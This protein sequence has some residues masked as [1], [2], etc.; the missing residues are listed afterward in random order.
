MVERTTPPRVVQ[1][2]AVLTASDAGVWL[3]DI[4]NACFGS[5]ADLPFHF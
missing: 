5:E 4:H 1:E 2:N 3:H